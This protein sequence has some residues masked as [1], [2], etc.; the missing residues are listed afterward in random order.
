MY[1]E[2]GTNELASPWIRRSFVACYKAVGIN[3]KTIRIVYTHLQNIEANIGSP[4]ASVPIEFVIS[5]I[6]QMQY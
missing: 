3:H 5:K 4:L 1:S 6:S 2:Q